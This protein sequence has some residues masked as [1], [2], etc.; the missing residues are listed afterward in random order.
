MSRSLEIFKIFLSIALI[1]S[2]KAFADESI[3]LDNGTDKNGEMIV[4]PTLAMRC[5][6][7]SQEP[8]I[9]SDCVD[10]LA[11]DFRSDELANKE[12]FDYKDMRR[13]IVGEYVTAYFEAS[14]KQLINVSG[15]QDRI[16]DELC[17]NTTSLSCS[18]I[19][20]DIRDEIEYNNKMASD[21]AAVLLDAV[22]LRAQELNF[23][24][25][26]VLLDKLVPEKEV[27]LENKSLA[28]PP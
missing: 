27:D 6:I 24:S 9:T 28:G 12:F 16:E 4:S 15:Y 25:I 2:A 8:D 14:I 5:G 11:Y 21:N 23:N 10:R 17:I 1:I 3:S 18:S 26:L 7:T 20:N 13:A 19:S 22:K